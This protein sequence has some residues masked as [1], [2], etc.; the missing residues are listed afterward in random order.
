MK[1]RI[2]P[3]L[4][5]ALGGF[6]VAVMLVANA[7]FRSYLAGKA[8]RDLVGSAS[9][10]FAKA[11]VVYEPFHLNGTSIFCNGLT[12]QGY[13]EAQFARLEA[14]QLRADLNWRGLFDRV[15]QVDDL[16]VQRLR[17]SLGDARLPQTAEPVGGQVG[18]PGSGS[19]WMPQRAAFKEVR[20]TETAL[21]WEGGGLERTRLR[22]TP[23]AGAWAIAGDGGTLTHQ[24]FPGLNLNSVRMRYRAPS[25]FIT[26]ASL[27]Q[28]G[29]GLLS[30]SGEITDGRGLDLQ[31]TL[32]SVP[33]EPLLAP[34]WRARL[35]GNLGGSLRITSPLPTGGRSPEVKG[36]L[37]LSQGEL[38]GLPI[39]DQIATFTR[40]QQ[41]RTLSLSRASAEVDHRD[42]RVNVSRFLLESE[43][44]LRVQGD[45]VLSG[46]MIAG[47]FQVGVTPSSLRWLP[48]SRDKV[49]TVSRDG[50]LWTEVRLSGPVNQPQ[51]DLTPRL[52]AAA[53]ETVIKDVEGTV[54]ETTRGVLD[55][56]KTLLGP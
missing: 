52:V 53:G 17:V 23:E 24:G 9:S 50:Y 40:T 55:A 28:G 20:I 42:G 43:G 29:E 38:I 1:A 31:L 11:E 8:F 54:R 6:F 26:D 3:W 34:D 16:E 14:Q 49:F 33:V 15:W 7:W 2:L 18:T 37:S 35:K 30:V 5:L 48:G 21:Q 47:T 13:P 36:T 44:L 27:N 56:V 39:L 41:F 51:D 19:Q 25:L 46:G 45:F 12:A 4:L 32:R 10:R 22:L